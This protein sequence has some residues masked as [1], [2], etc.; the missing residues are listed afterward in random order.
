M[1]RFGG[2]FAHMLTEKTMRTLSKLALAPLLIGFVAPALAQGTGSKARLAFALL[3]FTGQRLSDITRLGRQ[4]VNGKTLRFTQFKGRN[5]K[6][7]QLELP[8]LSVL[9]QTIDASPTG[10]LNFLVNDLG[11]PFTDKGFGNWFCDRCIEAGVPGRA[12]G[13]RKAGAPIAAENG[14]TTH[15]LMAIFGWKSLAMAEKYTRTASQT[16]LAR[17]SM[18][19]PVPR[20]QN[21]TESCPTDTTSGTFLE[22]NSDE[23][24]TN[25][26]GGARGGNATIERFQ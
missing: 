8:I 10:D 13:L 3:L 11:R 20:E 1:L 12:H 2:A 5:Q 22:K 18:H 25:F 26:G 9:Q 15:E 19:H 21:R 23:S 16:K 17:S 14:A 4:H 7:T 6:P 24:N